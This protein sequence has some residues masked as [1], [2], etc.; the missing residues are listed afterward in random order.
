MIVDNVSKSYVSKAVEKIEPEMQSFSGRS[1]TN[2]TFEYLFLA[3]MYIKVNENHHSVQKAA[4][5]AQGVCDDGFR[6]IIGFMV[7]DVDST[8]T[9]T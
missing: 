2:A 1:L 4:Y 3:A 6:E 7:A 9:W 8:K 5:I